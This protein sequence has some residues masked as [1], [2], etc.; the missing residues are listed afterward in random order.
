MLRRSSRATLLAAG[1]LLLLAPAGALAAKKT[2][3]VTVMTRNVFLGADLIP[4]AVA[5]PG[6]EFEQR[7]GAMLNEVTAGDPVGRMQSIAGEIA[8]AKPDLVG[9]QEVSIWRTGPKGDPAPA[10]TVRFDFLAALR[11][12]LA[13]LKAS[14]RVVAL[15]YGLNV[16]GPTDQGVDVR[17]TLG[18]VVLAKK[19]VKVAHARSALFKDQLHF[20]TPA[21]G[22]VNTSRTYNALD[23]TVGGV[24][25]HFVNTHLEAYS[26]EFRLAQAKELVAG[27]LKSKLPTIL[28]GDLNSGPNLPKPEDRPPYQAIA[29]AGFKP[30]RAKAPSC[31]YTDLRGD[32]GWDH[33]VDWIMSKPGLTLLRSSITGSQKTPSGVHP[34]DHGGVVS[35]LR[36]RG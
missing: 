20:K 28:A 12:E 21:L 16:E 9:L 29:K 18:D 19:G 13:R 23:A 6:A 25:L 7:G 26:P 34:A 31:C 5:A 15:R 4:L 35:V 1:G 32:A 24:R 3:T 2:A 22:D 10:T 33:N 30:R 36:V 8:G 14:Y 27:T 11:A 17:L